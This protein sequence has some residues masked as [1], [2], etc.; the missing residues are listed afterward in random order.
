MANRR[1]TITRSFR[2]ALS[3]HPRHLSHRT[4]LPFGFIPRHACV[5]T[6]Q[7]DLSCTCVRT[8]KQLTYLQICGA[9]NLVKLRQ[10]LAS[11]K[12]VVWNLCGCI[13]TKTLFSNSRTRTTLMSAF[14]FLPFASTPYI[15]ALCGNKLSEGELGIT[16]RWTRATIACFVT[17]TR[18]RRWY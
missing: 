8:T 15:Y 16:R 5:D 13:F 4:S 3:N 1:P 18:Y 10:P 12:T 9:P 7:P 17:P 14:A 11:L 6:H 2:V